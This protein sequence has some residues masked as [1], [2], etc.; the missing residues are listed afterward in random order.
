MRS[1]IRILQAELTQPGAV[2]RMMWVI[3]LAMALAA[4]QAVQAEA[5]AAPESFADLAE[6]VSPA[7]VNITTTTVVA[8]PTGAGRSAPTRSA[9]AS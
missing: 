3:L 2:L 8:A 4:A 5:R 6:K 7:V 1:Q 9:R